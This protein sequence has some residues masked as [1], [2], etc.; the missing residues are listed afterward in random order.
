MIRSLLRLFRW[1][2]A[3]LNGIVAMGGFFF[4]PG[5]S[6]LVPVLGVLCGVTLLAAASSAFNQIQERDIDRMM[7]RT[8]DRPI[9]QGFITPAMASVL[10]VLCMLSGLLALELGSG[11]RHLPAILGLA[12]MAWYLGVY[13]PLKRH[14]PFALAVGGV[15]GAL[16]PVI[17][18][19]SAGGH[20]LNY[21]IIL[22]AG[23]LYLWQ[24]PHF[25]LFQRRHTEDYRRAGLPF[26][27]PEPGRKNFIRICR[28]WVAGLVVGAFLLPAFGLVATGVAPWYGAGLLFFFLLSLSGYEKVFYTVLN[29]FPGL[30][31]FALFFRS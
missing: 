15:C 3:L 29:F 23:L 11:K 16:P 6:G 4:F 2:L 17:G 18:W 12:A 26:F 25:W 9:P 20:P 14:S 28:L 8:C 22:V 30:I 31:M 10:G 19:V 1:R 21:P 5:R 13:T 27:Q 7:E 24:I